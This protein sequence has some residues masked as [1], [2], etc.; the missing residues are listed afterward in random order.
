MEII[1]RVSDSGDVRWNGFPEFSPRMSPSTDE[2]ISSVIPPYP[3]GDHQDIKSEE[4]PGCKWTATF[5]ENCDLDFFEY[6]SRTFIQKTDQ[7]MFDHSM[8]AQQRLHDGVMMPTRN[9]SGHP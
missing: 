8:A 4:Y 2:M 9:N 1:F 7:S 3:D 5:N 6:V